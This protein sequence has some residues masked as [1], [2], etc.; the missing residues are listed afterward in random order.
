MSQ[1]RKNV[2]ILM[3]DEQ[4]VDTIG[5]YGNRVA[6]T[7]HLDRL[8]SEAARF[9]A[10]Y[11]PYSLC[12]P[13]RASLWTGMMPHNHHVLA[14]WLQ[15]RPDLKDGGMVQAFAD[16]GYHTAYTGKWHVPG[17]SPGR[18]GFAA[19]VAIPDV[20]DGRDRGRH[21]SE[22]RAYATGL[23]YQLDPA[24]LE[25]LTFAE[26]Q[27]TLPNSD[28][29]CG[30]SEIPVEHHL[31]TW[32]TTQFL[33]QLADRPQ[34]KPFFAVC[35]H[36]APHFPMIVPEP[37]ASLIHPDH[38]V[39]PPNFG[40][41]LEGKPAEV[42]S[43]KH[44]QQTQGLDE[45]AWRSL[46]AHYW[47]FCSLIDAQVGRVVDWLQENGLYQDTIIVYLSDHGDMIGSHGLNLKG[48]E[49]QYEEANR[50]PLL[51]SHPNF[52]HESQRNMF[53]SLVDL[54]PTLAEFCGV[55]IGMATDGVSFA[56]A[57]TEAKTDHHRDYVITEA[58]HAATKA[59][60]EY[61]DPGEYT[62]DTWRPMN[63]CIRTAL[64]KYVFHGKDTDEYYD[65]MADPHETMNRYP[66]QV[67][68]ERIG[69][70]RRLILGELSGSAPNLAGI[71]A[72]KMG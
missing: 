50:V 47:G 9:N 5:A 22:Y 46:I 34:D 53:V 3:S 37:Y 13:A 35:S 61:E 48:F 67:S 44:Y 38:V 20:I 39:L 24:D 19:S 69:E 29:L 31:E 52:R 60:G 66:S 2:L 6:R 72:R 17:T 64:D 51:I 71:V 7:P 33:R 23:G 4:R 30:S 25:N 26:Q 43:S 16:A 41:G 36:N 70:L 12:C 65:L 32:Q 14:N 49:V 54:L 27:M 10:C 59:R 18:L 15:V 1:R 45:R 21:I 55:D 68:Q 57:M 58:F 56:S 8:A 40:A 63:I 11:T 28:V 62:A 42:R